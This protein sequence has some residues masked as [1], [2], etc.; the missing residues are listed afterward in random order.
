MSATSGAA[1]ANDA[2]PLGKRLVRSAC[3]VVSAVIVLLFIGVLGAL[4]VASA[5]L[6]Q[7]AVPLVAAPT[8]DEP[9]EQ[10]ALR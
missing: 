4:L 6:W 3:S 9:K 2:Q 1:P 7:I 5:P 10:T 8:D